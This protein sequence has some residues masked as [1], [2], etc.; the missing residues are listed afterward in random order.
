[1]RSN[2]QL[3]Y[4]YCLTP[5]AGGQHVMKGGVIHLTRSS[6]ISSNIKR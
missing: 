5:T 4:K 6:N 3:Y 2:L 1:M